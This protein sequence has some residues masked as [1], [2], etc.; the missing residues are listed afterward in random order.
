MSEIEYRIGRIEP[1]EM[2]KSGGGK[3]VIAATEEAGKLILSLYAAGSELAALHEQVA[4]KLG[5]PSGTI[6]GGGKI[7][8]ADDGVN[9]SDYSA[10]FGGV[11]ADAA[12]EFAKL[13][14]DGRKIGI[15]TDFLS[16]QTSWE[17]Y[18]FTRKR[19][20]ET[21]KKYRPPSLSAEEAKLMSELMAKADEKERS[22]PAKV[23]DKKRGV[24]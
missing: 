16:T 19:H 12:E 14:A 13:L 18:G 23:R 7:G 5:V 17:P 2:R 3:F 15:S 4:E 1:P 8:F 10:D 20:L 21:V 6:L 9:L 24:N 11:P 22:K